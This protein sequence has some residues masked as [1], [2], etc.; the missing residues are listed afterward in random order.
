MGATYST[1]DAS[2]ANIVQRAIDWADLCEDFRLFV[3]LPHGDPE[4]LIYAHRFTDTN[5]QTST[6]SIDYVQ[7]PI[8]NMQQGFS[9]TE[10]VTASSTSKTSSSPIADYEAGV[11]AAGNKPSE[12]RHVARR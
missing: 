8:D 9:N 4:A 1:K 11:E 10:G 12:E 6:T 5:L 7:N 3:D 2:I